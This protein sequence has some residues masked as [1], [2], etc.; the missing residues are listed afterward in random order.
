MTASAVIKTLSQPTREVL[1]ELR[2]ILSKYGV[3]KIIADSEVASLGL[4]Y[5]AASHEALFSE[6]DLIFAVGGDGTILHTAKVA[7]L[8]GKPVLGINSGR[9]GF[10]AA[11]ECNELARLSDYFDGNYYIE[12]RMT[13]EATVDDRK[14]CCL[15][16]A[17]ISKGVMS[18]IVDVDV[19]CDGKELLSFRGDGLIISTPTGS[20]AY[21]LSAGGPAIDP[22]I[23]CITVTPICPHSLLTRP[24]VLRHDSK[25]CVHARYANSERDV[26][27]TSDGEDAVRITGAEVTVT[28]SPN[29]TARFIRIKNES[30]CE[31]LNNKIMGKRT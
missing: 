12:E 27:L 29:V 26:Y 24:V 2:V 17:V 28:G 11:L 9:L 20:T 5:T 23:D 13:L 4:G 3:N 16:D 8:Y 19:T 6:S 7:A 15:N 22:S 14:Y 31:I 1:A 21:S 10:M 18:Q 30:F 25:I